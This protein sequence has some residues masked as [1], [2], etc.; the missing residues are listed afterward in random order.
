MINLYYTVFLK[1]IQGIHPFLKFLFLYG[2]PPVAQW[3][4]NLTAVAQVTADAWVQSLAQ[5]RGLKDLGV[6]IAVVLVAAVA[7]IQSLARE[8]PCA[9]GAA[10]KEKIL[11][12]LCSSC[13]LF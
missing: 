2:V 8:H 4:E 1:Y 12:F 6:A 5:H 11:I 3:V 10:R 9:M 13:S 7:Q